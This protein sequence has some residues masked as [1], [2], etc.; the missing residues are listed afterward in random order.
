MVIINYIHANTEHRTGLILQSYSGKPPEILP[1]IPMIV[2]SVSNRAY[3]T[4][5]LIPNTQG[6]MR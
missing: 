2:S 1:N 4:L 3:T 6:E 5:Q